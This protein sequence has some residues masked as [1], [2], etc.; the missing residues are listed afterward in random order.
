MAPGPARRP[1]RPRWAGESSSCCAPAGPSRRRSCSRPAPHVLER[2][3]GQ[4]RTPQPIFSSSRITLTPGDSS[5]STMNSR[6]PTSPTRLHRGHQGEEVGRA[7]VGDEA[8]LALMSTTRPCR[9]RKV[10]MAPSRCRPPVRWPRSTR[11]G[12][13]AGEEPVLLLRRA[14]EPQGMAGPKFS[15]IWAAAAFTRAMFSPG[16]PTPSTPPRPA[17]LLRVMSESQPSSR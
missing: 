13:P 6:G 16:S 7:P 1:S 10:R 17:V 5:A 3:G 8:L 4:R 14:E 15:N 12:A 11:C 9:R 2:Q